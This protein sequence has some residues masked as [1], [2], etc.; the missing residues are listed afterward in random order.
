MN[1]D[2]RLDE[3]A[4]SA[5][6]P[7]PLVERAT[8][9]EALPPALKLCLVDGHALAYRMN[10][11]LQN[12]AMT[13][14]GGEQTHALY[15]FCTKLL[16]LST[17]FAGYRT[18]V[19]FDRPEPTFRS[20]ELPS[21]KANRPSM[22][23][24]LR[25]QLQAIIEACALLGAPPI[26]QPGFEA[27]DVIA[28]CVREATRGGA[29]EIV[30]VGTDKDLLQL[31]T[32]DDADD[33]DGTA[34]T[35]RPCTRVTVW[36]DQKKVSYDAEA[37]VAKHG[38]RPSQIVDLLSLMGDASDNV[39]GVPGVGAK[40]AAKLLGEHGTLD[41]VLLAATNKKKPN[42]VM[43]SLVEHA[44]TARRARRLVELDSDAPFNGDLLRGGPMKF[45]A[46][47]LPAFL[48]RWELRKVDS[49]IRNLKRTSGARQ[50]L[51]EE[52]KKVPKQQQSN[53]DRPPRVTAKDREAM[54][55]SSNALYTPGATSA[56]A[57]TVSEVV[58]ES[59]GQSMAVSGSGSGEEDLKK[60]KVPELKER[61]KAAGK[62]VS[63][64]K[65]ALIKRLLE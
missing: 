37:V 31:V 10:F 25:L 27:D 53:G 57:A 45:E 49:M 9:A 54:R 23:T 28:S 55:Q 11:A 30:I 39:P 6:A 29:S 58:V 64:K 50:F 34:A 35:T 18:L 33:D 4:A 21:Y 51:V 46:H 26:S 20:A 41:E 48:Q 17:R 63:G 52:A 19:A 42:K 3:E 7:P 47:G 14:V 65:A 1:L 60:L 15:G 22:P 62:P 2:D 61:L 24:P 16:D 8:T 5:A 44:E 32:D 38:V 43:S 13:T 36:N 40:T 12:T 56:A 59:N